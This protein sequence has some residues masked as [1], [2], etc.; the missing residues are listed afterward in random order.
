[1]PK[2]FVASGCSFTEGRGWPFT[3]PDYFPDVEL[4][5]MGMASQGN[6]F[7][8]RKAQYK[9]FDLL[10]KGVNPKDIYLGVMWS[11]PT[12]ME[13]FFEDMWEEPLSA[14]QSDGWDPNTGNPSHFIPEAEGSWF[15]VDI[16]W[17]HSIAREWYQSSLSN[18][19]A[20]HIRTYEYILSTQNFC[21]SLG[22]DF[23]M[24]QFNRW[25]VEDKHDNDLNL[26]WMRKM[27]DW[28]KWLP[29]D[30]CFE[31]VFLNST[32]PWPDRGDEITIDTFRHPTTAQHKEFTQCAI[33]PHLK[34]SAW[35]SDN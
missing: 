23:F 3:I 10:D 34:Q 30:G 33:V 24:T 4:H 21:K 32:N 14:Q 11:G 25:V 8:A 5:N 15:I 6:G 1:M 2:H 26:R 7:I 22:I 17:S 27:I 13:F 20:Y 9:I 18:A 31:W 16:N 28:D 12:R 19:T 35:G 29:I